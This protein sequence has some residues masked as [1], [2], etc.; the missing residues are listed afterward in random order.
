MIISRSD[1]DSFDKRFRTNL[2]NCLS[3]FK[4]LNLIGTRSTDKV[5]NLGLYSQVVH[6]GAN[7]PLQGV[8]FRPAVVPRHTLENIFATRE[9]TLN[10]VHRSFYKEAHWASARWDENEFSQVGLTEEYNGNNHAP[11]VKESLIKTL[12]TFKERH[13]IQTNQTTLLVGEVEELVIQDDL[14]GADGFIDLEKA[15]TV[16]VSG[17]DKYHTT[18][19]L[20]RLEYAKTDKAPGPLTD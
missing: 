17:L 11:F 12:L 14:I 16:T 2:I 8:I 6:V 19:S 10:Q 5:A 13:I 18:Q 20:E 7:P 3:G 1:I 4:S 15:E 9:F